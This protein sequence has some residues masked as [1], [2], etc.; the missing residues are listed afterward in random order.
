VLTEPRVAALADINGDGRLDVVLT[1]SERN[2]LSILL[3]Q[4]DGS[5]VIGYGSPIDVGLPAYSA[6][7][8]DVNGDAK[9]DL[10]IA[11]VNSVSTPFNSKLVV[12]LSDGGGFRQAPGSPFA[13]GPGAYNVALA[14][15]NSDG[16][17]DIAASSF[18]GDAVTL[19][20][21]Q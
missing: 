4:G 8:S 17:Q 6:A 12:L 20:L 19:L 16:K 11:T 18:E 10:V 9:A 13:A 2:E 15:V 3:N 5:L 14:D 21:G 1:H 7:V